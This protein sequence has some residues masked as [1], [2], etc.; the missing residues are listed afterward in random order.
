[1]EFDAMSREPMI[2]CRSLTKFFGTTAALDSVDLDIR[3]GT[4]HAL[5]GE[6]G[7]GKSTCLGIIGG[8]I[9]PTSGSVRIAGTPYRE[10]TPRS[11]RQM[12]VFS[13]Y[14]ELTIV[15][16][17]SAQANV[18]ISS[19]R[20]RLGVL[21]QRK[22]REE[23][24]ALCDR[25]DVRP[26]PDV[27]AGALSA[28]DQQIVEILR[29]L[30]G[31]PKVILLD[32]PTASLAQ[33]ERDAL[34]RLMRDLRTSGI[35][36]GFVS[37][38]LKEVIDVAD[39]VTVFRDGAVT[40]QFANDGLD[41]GQ[42]VKAML[43]REAGKRQAMRT[44]RASG[45][46][47]RPILTVDNL[48][49]RGRP[50]QQVSFQ[51]RRGEILGIAGLVGS[52][53]TSLLTAL[54]G[55][56][57]RARGSLRIDGEPKRWPRSPFQARKLGIALLPEDRKRSGLVLSRPAADNILLSDFSAASR[58]GVLSARKMR[59]VGGAASRAFDFD[60]SRLG[61]VARRFSG[62]NQQKL[63]M[64]RWAHVRPTILLADEPT[65]GIDVGAKMEILRQLQDMVDK[66]VSVVL[67]SSEIEEILSV[68]H[69]VMVLAK[70]R[71]V[72][73]FD[74]ALGDVSVADIIG[75]EFAF[76]DRPTD[77]PA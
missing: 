69:R 50:L 7:A 76:A 34:L 51:L 22:M 63:L 17:L 35:T 15:P 64:A 67:V 26:H 77:S 59:E 30:V 9:R 33:H 36:M 21:A 57:P 39:Y 20:S 5:V 25:Y 27:P 61:E 37:H 13:V 60:V 53:R 19:P 23:Y 45:Q 38:N 47:R 54:A 56:Q 10:W 66:G 40:G 14:Q 42:L 49:I 32:E 73:E 1:M 75:A 68:S 48:S 44:P 65:R 70:G 43:G 24:V 12:G 58:F 74:N 41:P 28:A 71:F 16:N 2:E 55:A 31:A 18:F 11:I 6:N 8:R 4:I 29:V 62:G 3:S 46:V 72:A 52:G